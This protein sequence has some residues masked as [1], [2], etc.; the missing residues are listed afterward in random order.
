MHKTSERMFR[1]FSDPMTPVDVFTGPDVSEALRPKDVIPD[2]GGGP[3]SSK[4]KL[5]RG[6][7]CPTGRE[8]KY[9]LLLVISPS[10]LISM[11]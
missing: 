9:V 3:Y 8:P 1:I 2:A 11:L 7:N 10:L 6:I 4:V 5:S